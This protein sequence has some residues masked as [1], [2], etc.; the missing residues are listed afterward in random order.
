MSEMQCADGSYSIPL[1]YANDGY[2][3]CDDGSDEAQY[4][5]PDD[6]SVFSCT[7]GSDI[8][9]SQFND[10]AVD[11][12]DG[13]DEPA[14]F[15]CDDGSNEIPFDY[16]NDGYDDC[17]DGSDESALEDLN[18]VDCYGSEDGSTLTASEFH[19]GS[20]D[21]ETGWDE[22][23]FEL[24]ADCEWSGDGIGWM[25]AEVYLPTDS[26]YEMWM[27]T[28]ESGLEII[29]LNSTTSDGSVMTVMFDASTHAFLMMEETSYDEDGVMEEHM[30]ITTSNYDPTLID[31]LTVDTTLDTHAPPFAVVFSGEPHTVDDG[32]VFVCDDGEEVPF[33]YANDGEE[34]CA[35]GSDEPAYEEEFFTCSDDGSEIPMS[36]VNDG[37]DDCADGSDEP[38]YDSDGYETSIFVCLHSGVDGDEIP[39]SYVNDGMVDCQDGSDEEEGYSFEIS[40]FECDDGDEIDLS[41]V[42]D[43]EENCM[44]ASDEATV[45]EGHGY[46]QYSFTSTGIADWTVGADTNMLEIVFTNCDSFADGSSLFSNADYLIPSDCGDELARY[47][48]AE[49]MNGDITGLSM[50]D[51]SD[52]SNPEENYVLYIDEDFELE[53]WNTV[54][55]STPDGEYADE[56]PQ[57]Q[58]PA[59]GIGVAFIAMLGAAMLA[60]RR[61][62]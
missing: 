56:N 38:A 31:A 14:T 8:T 27:H 45:G 44:D 18:I 53:G 60:G 30:M 57:V 47:S 23:D 21:C 2:D 34:D 29:G 58:L 61:N 7:D 37:E 55:L 19:D 48:M 43:G 59:P 32:K 50:L 39:L 28:D 25:C 62:E 12:A 17:E 40:S 33:A 15:M 13:S 35:D 52:L 10:G 41:Q 24:S 22:M 5:T 6:E 11:C 4:E 51:E 3:D 46:G 54:R 26:T 20:A 49:I 36:S 1:S 9:V 16:V 42:N